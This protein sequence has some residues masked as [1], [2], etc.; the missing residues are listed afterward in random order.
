MFKMF[1]LLKLISL[2]IF[3]LGMPSQVYA[4]GTSL[5]QPDNS[6]QSDFQFQLEQYRRSYSEFILFRGDYRKNNTLENE[7]KSVIAGRNTLI[8]RE[9]TMSSFCRILLESIGRSRVNHIQTINSI[10]ELNLLIKDYETYAQ[11]ANSIQTKNDL[12]I[13]SQ[14]Y[15]ASQSARLSTLNRAQIINKVTQLMRISL[16]LGQ[17]LE[18][19]RTSLAP[20]KDL[21]LVAS[22][23]SE[24]DSLLGQNNLAI[25]KLLTDLQTTQPDTIVSPSIVSKFGAKLPPIQSIQSHLVDRIIDLDKNYVVR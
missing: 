8:A 24:S 12:V 13:Y 14:E 5:P 23:L 16:D 9:L 22:G 15:N 4:Q 1:R 21:P 19:L 6:P 17:S 20:S 7:Q 3:F 2:F 25:E 10:N 11:R 18:Q